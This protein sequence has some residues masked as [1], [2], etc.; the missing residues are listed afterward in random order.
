MGILRKVII[1]TLLSY[2]L[3]LA[4]G[5][6]G[7]AGT[8]AVPLTQQLMLTTPDND[9]V[10]IRYAA[11]VFKEL[12]TRLRIKIT[13]KPL[14]KIRS[15]VAAND[16]DY[17]GLANRVAGLEK[18]YQNLQRVT[19][20]HLAVQHI[21][22]AKE[23]EIIDRVTDFKS[24]YE[25]FVKTNRVVGFLGGSAKA[26]QELSPLPKKNKQALNSPE[27]AF[28]MLAINRINAYLAGPGMVNR[29][30]FKEKFG[31]SDIKEVGVFSRFPLFSYLHKRH[32][33]LIPKFEKMI[34]AMLKD[35][36]IEK[37]R[38]LVE[39]KTEPARQ[40]SE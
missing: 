3:F 11:L 13:V 28:G 4:P 29:I 25:T 15:L 40:N 9:G 32:A 18:R 8:A 12:G 39:E 17:D 5:H 31:K 30:I 7:Q 6:C 19:V 36:T 22:Y 24:L 16:G 27:Q 34:H 20:S 21:L 33:A 26:R 10:L 23:T 35:G 2:G 14:P 1:W 38:K 37:I